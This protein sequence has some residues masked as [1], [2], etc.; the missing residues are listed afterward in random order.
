MHSDAASLLDRLSLSPRPGR[1]VTRLG[2]GLP[3]PDARLEGGLALGALHEI[4]AA[5]A[6]DIGAATG[7]VVA[8]LAGLCA[9]SGRDRVLWI[10]D[11]ATAR[12]AGLPCPDGI[13]QYGLD[14]SRLTLVHPVDVKSALWAA[15]EGA[16]CTDLAAVVL[17][18]HGNPPLFDRVAGRRLMLRAQE[19]GVTVLVLR[20][21]GVAE[22]GAALTRWRVAPLPSPP[23]PEFPE[24]L[25]LP[26]H[27]LIL[28]R[29]RTGQTGDWPVIWN[30]KRRAFDHGRIDTPPKDPLDRLPASAHRPDRAGQMGQVVDLRRTP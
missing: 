20:Q 9:R 23:D 24:G 14:P 13:A 11:P 17:H 30:P 25:G 3:A 22:A 5:E 29:S 7:L 12:D 2:L 8:L 10:S 4:R 16:R 21:S 1:G 18:L 15:E 26:Q 27:R 6:R 19:S 28:E